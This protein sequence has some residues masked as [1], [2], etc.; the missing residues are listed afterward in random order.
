M[1]EPRSSQTNMGR[2]GSAGVLRAVGSQKVMGFVSFLEWCA[3]LWRP[4]AGLVGCFQRGLVD[5]TPMPRA[6]SA[7]AER[8]LRARPC[9]NMYFRPIGSRTTFFF[10]RAAASRGPPG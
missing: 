1:V 3:P 9:L 7:R 8:A 10:P 4:S 2:E 5:H 6:V